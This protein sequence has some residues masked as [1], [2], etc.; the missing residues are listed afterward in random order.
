MTVKNPENPGNGA[1]TPHCLSSALDRGET[2]DHR[3]GVSPVLRERELVWGI[4]RGLTRGLMRGLVRGDMRCAGLVLLALVALVGLALGGCEEAPTRVWSPADHGEETASAQGGP[5]GNQARPPKEQVQVGTA[6]PSA[7]HGD[8][9]AG[10]RG[11]GG[12]PKHG[13][14]GNR[15]GAEAAAPAQASMDRA[16][17]LL[18]QMQC[19]TC[20][21]TNGEGHGVGAPPGAAIPDMRDPAWQKTR[22]DTQLAASI[23]HGKG[24]M[25]AYGEQVPEE[26][27]Q[28]LVR[29]IRGFAAR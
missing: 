23:R 18:W 19:T 25:P 15:D 8:G 20:H 13:D 7:P 4:T 9:H 14:A 11:E 29:R 22:S 1:H 5:A 12:G 26:G 21:G 2:R 6:T 27:I 3:E 16:A 10:D 24:L 17:G 28:A